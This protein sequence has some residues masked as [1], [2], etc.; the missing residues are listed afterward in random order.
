[1][2]ITNEQLNSFIQSTGQP[3]FTQVKP[4][5]I[6]CYGGG[7][8][9][10]LVL[11]PNWVEYKNIYPNQEHS[12]GGGWVPPVDIGPDPSPVSEPAA[13]GLFMVGGLLL[14]WSKRWGRQG[15]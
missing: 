4:K 7:C 2:L 12:F 10:G 6:Y 8:E 5:T 9:P 14:W 1:M 15:E 13:L 3:D 11:S